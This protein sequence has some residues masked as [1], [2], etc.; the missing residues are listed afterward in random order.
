MKTRTVIIAVEVECY[1]TINE[2]RQLLKEN[3][4]P[5]KITQAQINVVKGTKPKATK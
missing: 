5:G 1:H 2:I 4:L 3:I